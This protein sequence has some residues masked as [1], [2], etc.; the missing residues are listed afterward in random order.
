[1]GFDPVILLYALIAYV[2]GSFSAAIITC[3]L[4]GLPDP[5]SA[6]SNNPGATNVLRV[7]G[8]KAARSRSRVLPHFSVIYFHYFLVSGVARVSRLF[9]ARYLAFTGYQVCWHWQPG[10][11]WR[12]YQKYLRCRRWCLPRAHP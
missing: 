8:K 9:T 12:G 4:M 5:R 7:G 1:M 3:K 2:L 10:W 6:G 11:L